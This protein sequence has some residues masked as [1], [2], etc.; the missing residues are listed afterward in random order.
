LHLPG[1]ARRAQRRRAPRLTVRITGL[2]LPAAFSV[3]WLYSLAIAV[4][5]AARD[6]GA[7]NEARLTRNA[8][9][10]F[11]ISSPLAASAPGT[12][13]AFRRPDQKA[14]DQL[15]LA[16]GLKVEFLTREA[17]NWTDMLAFFP[18]QRPTHLISCVEAKRETL[19][20]GRLNPSVQRIHLGTGKVE[21]VLRGMD[22]CDGIR[23]TP[24]GTILVN[25]ETGD[26]GVYEILDPLAVREQSILDRATGVVSDPQ[27]VVK[28]TAL[29][30]MAWEGMAVLESGVVIAGDELAPGVDTPGGAI[31]KFIPASP[32]TGNTPIRK[33]RDSPLAAGR[34]YALQVS[35]LETNS[36]SGQG[37]ETGN[38][39]WVE[40]NA[41][42]A[43]AEA[44]AKQATDYYRPEDL[45]RD[46]AFRDP[47][48]PQ[49]VRFC[50]ANTGNEA[51]GHYGEVLCAVDPAPLLAEPGSRHVMVTRFLEGDGDFNSFDNLAFQPGSGN[52]YVV[53]DHDNG[54]VLACLPDGTDRD[55]RS[56]GCVRVASVRDSSAEPTGLIFTADGKTAYLVIQHSDD[57]HMPA[58][59]GHPTDDVLKISG[60]RR[61]R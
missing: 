51:A 18:A 7:G 28:R 35:C 23:A 4:P 1:S 16:P 9:S 24:W 49:A 15:L 40:V 38:A 47:R 6:T 14:A 20:D 26:G 58:V 45:E 48:H 60:F 56:D 50:W 2:R 25:E 10:R 19:A 12:T 41:A 55:R 43:R 22:R 36:Q 30:V 42:T 39:A 32:R 29:P 57:R 46:P 52:L 13:G 31:Y 44:A 27:H 8:G 59:D 33:L 61:P 53:E 17:A 11:G 3:V 37:C 54:D 21:T 34:V 5:V